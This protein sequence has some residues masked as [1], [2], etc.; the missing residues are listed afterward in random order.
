MI[1]VSHVTKTYKNNL[2]LNDICFSI[3]DGDCVGIVGYN[4]SGKSVLLKLLCGFTKP[5]QGT[6]CVDGKLIGKDTDFLQNAGAFIN[7]PHFMNHMSGYENLAILAEIRKKIGKDEILNVLKTVR[8]FDAKD[9]KVKTYS[10]GMLQR[11]RIAQAIMEQ[12]KY[13]LMDE[14]MNALDEE[15]HHVMKQVF[16]TGKQN[17][18]TILFTAH[19]REDVYAFADYVLRI[20]E[21]KVEKIKIEELAEMD[22]VTK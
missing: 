1:E 6:I 15:G 18:T 4:G 5:D 16:R 22:N 12:P 14:P 11:L 20:K 21:K 19:N 2:V 7:S 13:L 8:L 10:Q 3:E 9:K 17:G